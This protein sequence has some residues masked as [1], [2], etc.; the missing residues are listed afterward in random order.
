[1]VRSSGVAATRR[2][3]TPYGFSSEGTTMATAAHAHHRNGVDRP[4]PTPHTRH[5]PLHARRNRLALACVGA[6][7]VVLVLVLIVAF[8]H[9]ALQT[10]ATPAVIHDQVPSADLFIQSITQ[11]DGALGWHQLCPSLQAQ[12]SES[13]LVQA[14]QEQ[15]TE[16]AQQSVTLTAGLISARTL[17]AGGQV[18]QYLLTAHWPD[19]S[20]Q[21]RTYIVFT[22]A[23]G[24]VT[25]IQGQ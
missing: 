21:V 3:E 2:M 1:M 24:C 8:A 13:S 9:V 12:V 17:S 4:R 7:C 16:L 6:L 20:T 19:G 14:A 5:R 18:R 11:D 22:E 10:Q 15:R 23:S 25:D